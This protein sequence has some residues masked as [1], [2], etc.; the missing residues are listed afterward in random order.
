MT[1]AD[2]FISTT[3]QSKQ[4]ASF[5]P[6]HLPLTD[7]IDLPQV[8]S[9]CFITDA[10]KCAGGEYGGANTPDGSSGGSSGGDDP[11]WELDNKERCHKEG[12]T[13][14]SC[15]SSVQE[16]VNY[17]PYDN[18]YFEKCMCKTNLVTCTKPYYG[19]GESC[20]GKY[21]S[22][23]LDNARAC[24]E[25]GE[26]GYTQTGSCNSI[27]NINK[28][29]PYDANYFDKCVCR[30]DLYTC[31]SPLQ[32]VG[33]AC[34]GK[35]ASCQCPSSYKSCDC[36]GAAGASS[37][38]WSGITRYSNCKA[39][40][41]PTCQ[42][43][44]NCKYGSSTVDDGCGGSCTVCNKTGN[45]HCPD[46]SSVPDVSMC[47]KDPDGVIIQEDGFCI[48]LSKYQ[49][50]GYGNSAIAST[51][52]GW[53]FASLSVMQKASLH[54]DLLNQQLNKIGEP[55][56]LN[57]WY[58]T[59]TYFVY[60]DEEQLVYIINPYSGEYRESAGRGESGIHQAYYRYYKNCN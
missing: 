3:A 5:A 26:D 29:C 35:Y 50:Y 19:V 58:W 17:C 40:C 36:G 38:T 56:L 59:N 28:R 11:E 51:P 13:L 47:Q 45:Y 43:E 52:A 33:T 27:Q 30:S 4:R 18:T 42:N 21:A 37:C 14:T 8:A 55:D 24:K 60:T 12:Y 54:I 1:V 48:I 15:S 44:S 57:T 31:S 49:G 7:G 20:G 16:P 9:V 34:G 22:C 39:C 25:D 46:G 53:K 6:I 23:K 10:G 41:E 2:L 32:G